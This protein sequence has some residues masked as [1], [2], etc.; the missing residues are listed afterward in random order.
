MGAEVIA[1]A[2][3]EFANFLKAESAKWAN[4]IKEADIRAE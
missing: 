4:V 1:S 2:P 3:A